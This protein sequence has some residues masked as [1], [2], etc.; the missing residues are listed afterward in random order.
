MHLQKTREMSEM[1]SVVKRGR[2]Q[3]TMTMRFRT[4]RK[5]AVRGR[6]KRYKHLGG[7]GL[8]CKAPATLR[9]SVSCETSQLAET[10]NAGDRPRSW[11]SVR[12]AAAADLGPRPLRDARE[13]LR[14][15]HHWHAT[16]VT[17]VNT[18]IAMHGAAK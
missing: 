11:C 18:C 10:T 14:G 13:M 12:L 8:R 9:T 7:K 15:E 6:E 2:T 4:P 1:R 5:P 16:E 17:I 3:S